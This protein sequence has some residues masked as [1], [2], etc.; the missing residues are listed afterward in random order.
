MPWRCPACRIPIQHS[1]LEPTPRLSIR[2]R[3]H[4]CRLELILDP[5]T[6]VLTI[7]PFLEGEEGAGALRRART[8]KSW[9]QAK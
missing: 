9:R 4:V 3:C 5:D 2:Y 7:A 1:D 8:Q 6:D